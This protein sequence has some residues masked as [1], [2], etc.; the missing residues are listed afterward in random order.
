MS[1]NKD[2]YQGFVDEFEYQLNKLNKSFST[3]SW[4]RAVAFLA[5][6]GLLMVGVAD[7]VTA[8]DVAGVVMLLV[9]VWLV[10]KHSQVV[11]ATDVAKSKLLAATRYEERFGEKWREFPDTGEEFL[12]DEDTVA[13]DIDLLGRNSLYQLIST[14]HTKAGRKLLAEEIKGACYHPWDR[15]LAGERSA[16]I[17]ELGDKYDFAI[18]YEAAGIRLSGSMAKKKS[19]PD[20]EGF[21][22]FMKDKTKGVMPAWTGAVRLICPIIEIALIICAAVGVISYVY[23]LVGFIVLLAFTWLTS[24]ITAGVIYP[25]YALKTTAGAYRDMLELIYNEEFSSELLAELKS[26]VDGTDGAYNAFKAL[27]RLAQAYNISFNPLIHQILSGVLLWDYQVAYASCRWKRRYGDN[28]AEVFY[29]I[30]EVEELSSFAVLK[31]IRQTSYAEI[32]SSDSKVRLDCEDI[33]HPL[34]K[35]DEV[36]RNSVSLKSGVTI[37]TGS[38]MSG[39]TTFLR[40]IAI[41]LVLAYMGAP[42]CAKRLDASYMRIFSS[43]RVTDDVAHGISTFYAEILRIKAM[44]EYREQDEPMLC[45][46]DEIFKGTN[47]ADRIVGASEA[48]TRLAGD[49]CMTVV[50]THDFELCGL[51]D[52]S[53]AE[54]VNYHFEEYYEEDELKFDYKIRDG[55]CT[56]TNA[57]AILRM[58]GFDIK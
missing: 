8:A 27:D 31:N 10:R 19:E 41:N 32:D 12:T 36:V 49:R 22:A 47:S 1:D 57:L 15:E 6:A 37:I 50:S 11:R 30:A 25:F 48:I 52:R 24:T 18:S 40:T 56:T 21:S 33:Y 35:S 29:V 34:I 54:A 53:G 20:T 3:I 42:V 51:K 39:K 55:R 14:A 28:L 2:K 45:L 17:E 16:A 7:N 5:G 43:M 46:I 44:A 4:L 58:A 9:F 38:N 26:K 23:P 13:R